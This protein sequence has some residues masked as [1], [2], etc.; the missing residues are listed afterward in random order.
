MLIFLFSNGTG[1]A[2][3]EP[4]KTPEASP[5]L[6]SSPVQ[7]SKSEPEAAVTPAPVAE[8]ATTVSASLGSQEPEPETT[9][10]AEPIT[11][12]EFN[13]PPAGNLILYI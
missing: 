12:S 6:V 10:V 8:E 11:S 2:D 1:H 5:A 9:P 3:A 13:E 4:L 7:P